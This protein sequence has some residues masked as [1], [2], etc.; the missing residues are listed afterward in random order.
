M[1]SLFADQPIPSILI[2]VVGI[3][4]I[5]VAVLAGRLHWGGGNRVVLSICL[6]VLSGLFW[7]FSALSALLAHDR[8]P[9]M[10]AFFNVAAATF[11]VG[12]ATYG[13]E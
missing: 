7:Y 5:T 1:R 12:A 4:G 13:V 8:R 10:V 9:A 11:A 3:V 6:A 2:A